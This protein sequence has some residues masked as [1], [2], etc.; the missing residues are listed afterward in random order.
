MSWTVTFPP[1]LDLTQPELLRPLARAQALADVIRHVPLPP[2]TK[3]KFNRLNILRAVRG[4]TCIEGAELS[5]SEVEAV[6]AAGTEHVLPPSR[7]HEETEARN[8]FEVMQFI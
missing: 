3:E 5:E 8:A 1:T 7:Q 4:T 6:V 2:R